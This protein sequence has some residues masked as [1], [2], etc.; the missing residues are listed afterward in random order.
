MYLLKISVYLFLVYLIGSI[1]FGY[2]IT[3]LLKGFDIRTVGSHNIGATNVYRSVGHIAGLTVLILDIGKGFF[4]VWMMKAVFNNTFLCLLAAIS[5]I[6]GHSLSIFLKFKGG[7]GVATGCGAFFALAPLPMLISV[8]GFGVVLLFTRYA[9]LSSIVG[10]VIFPVSCLIFKQD[11][12]I[13]YLSIVASCIIIL[14]HFPNIK[15]LIKGT[16]RKIKL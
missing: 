2:I 7:R 1:P 16:E 9:S 15:R 3:Y 5:A 8:V 11:R 10:V 6:A 13:I 14:R 12:L 4:S